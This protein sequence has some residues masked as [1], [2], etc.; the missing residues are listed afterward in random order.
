[1][2]TSGFWLG[3]CTGCRALRSPRNSPLSQNPFPDSPA[4]KA[5]S[6][7][8]L[9]LFDLNGFLAQGVLEAHRE[10]ADATMGTLETSMLDGKTALSH[11]RSIEA[12]HQARRNNS[13][14]VTSTTIHFNIGFFHRNEKL[15]VARYTPVWFLLKQVESERCFRT[16]T[17]DSKCF[18]TA[19]DRAGVSLG[20]STETELETESSIWANM[21]K[22]MQH[23][24]W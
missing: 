8:N 9:L 13:E 23:R 15:S 18:V 4:L 17:R 5:G 11:P 24:S 2:P 12:S 19:A 7:R 22:I 20:G 3:F 16:T 1:M 10:T 6:R 21:N 14:A